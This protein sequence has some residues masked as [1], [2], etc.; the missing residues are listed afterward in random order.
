M[1]A[2][3]RAV[4]NDALGFLI[5]EMWANVEVESSSCCGIGEGGKRMSLHFEGWFQL[6]FLALLSMGRVI[7]TFSIDERRSIDW[8]IEGS[9]VLKGNVGCLVFHTTRVSLRT[10]RVSEAVGWHSD[11]LS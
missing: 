6:Y 4:G 2:V 11:S 9:Q 10:L 3:K 5:V 8:S 7:Q 1:V